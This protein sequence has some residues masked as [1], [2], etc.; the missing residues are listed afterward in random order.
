[1]GH[2]RSRIEEGESTV[3]KKKK[4]AFEKRERARV[5]MHGFNACM[6]E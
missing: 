4:A 2:K 6:E 3:Q 5:R 1:M